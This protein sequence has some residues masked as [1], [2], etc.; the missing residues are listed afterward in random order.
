MA[1]TPIASNVNFQPDSKRPGRAMLALF[2]NSAAIFKNVAAAG[3][4]FFV[5]PLLLRYLGPEQLGAL[6]AAGQWSGYLRYLFFGLDSAV[7]VI[8]LRAASVHN[9]RDTAALTKSAIRLLLKQSIIVLPIVFTLAWFVPQLVR[10]SPGLVSGMRLGMFIGSIA[11]LLGPMEVFGSVLNCL[12]LGYLVNIASL[13][14]TITI[15]A[16]A[17]A[18][19][20]MGQGL[21]GQFVASTCAELV[22]VLLVSRMA[23]KRLPGFASIAPSPIDRTELSK[24]RWPMTFMGVAGQFNV[25]TD[26]IVVSLMLR[27][28]AV[29]TFSITQRFMMTVG[30]LGTSFGASTWAG[31]AELRASGERDHFCARLLELVR[32]SIGLGLIVTVTAAAYNAR[33]V[34]LWVGS[35]YYGGN[36]LS[37]MTGL[38][39]VLF[40]FVTQFIWLIDMDGAARDRF[41]VS[42]FGSVL[43]LSLSILFARLL[44]LYGIS[45]ATV[46]AFALTDAWYAPLVFSRRFGVNFAVIMWQSL[47]CATIIVPWSLAI[48]IFAHRANA[49]QGWFR[50]VAEFTLVMVAAVC[51]FGFAVLTRSDRAAWQVRVRLFLQPVN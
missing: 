48:W 9:F 47:K 2:A 35:N 13:A 24:L 40:G 36:A 34:Y 38:Q 7:V 22:L 26:Y 49:P 1:A 50:F 45:L 31:L 15:G 4:G 33:F 27:P 41:A 8:I 32:L 43:N 6:R 10:V 3:I 18:L 39:Q 12:Q 25:M 19:A 29:T 46:F 37:L 51:Y 11:F 14:Q 23:I 30:M 42:T 5:T 20:W 21:V 28:L 16:L 17:V 44:G